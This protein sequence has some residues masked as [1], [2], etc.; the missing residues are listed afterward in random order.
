MRDASKQ[1][2]GDL[3]NELLWLISNS[4]DLGLNDY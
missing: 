3:R 4:D 2:E 1:R